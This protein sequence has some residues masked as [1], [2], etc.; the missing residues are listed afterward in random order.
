MPLVDNCCKK[1][2]GIFNGNRMQNKLKMWLIKLHFP[3]SVGDK[4]RMTYYY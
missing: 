3:L 1:K 4:W 2:I